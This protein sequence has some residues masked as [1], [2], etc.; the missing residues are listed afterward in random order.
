LAER[1]PFPARTPI[2]AADGRASLP[3]SRWLLNEFAALAEIR[4]TVMAGGV[5]VPAATYPQAMGSVAIPAAAYATTR[6]EPVFASYSGESPL[7]VAPASYPGAD[8]IPLPFGE[9]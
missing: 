1:S 6:A 2:A 7:S 5:P 9:Y 8:A 3:F 4:T